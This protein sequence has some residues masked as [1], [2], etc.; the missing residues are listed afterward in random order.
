MPMSAPHSSSA[1]VMAQ[2]RA[3]GTRWR[4]RAAGDADAMCKLVEIGTPPW[5]DP[6][7][8]GVLRRVTRKYEA[9]TTEPAPHSWFSFGA[10]YDTPDYVAMYEADEDYGKA[11]HCSCGSQIAPP[12]VPPF[13]T[14]GTLAS[15][16]SPGA[17]LSP[18]S[19]AMS[20][21][22]WQVRGVGSKPPAQR[23]GSPYRL[24]GILGHPRAG[25]HPTI[26]A[27]A[28]AVSHATP[29]SRC[30]GA[31]TCG[32]CRLP[33]ARHASASGC[34]GDEMFGSRLHSG[35]ARLWVNLEATPG[36]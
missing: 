32:R 35:K 20:A 23:P 9:K 16:I 34:N 14:C 13:F 11:P 3:I 36:A 30:A 17:R 25:W 21:F 22:S 29:V 6:R 33:L 12:Y 2:R 8:F 19:K 1:I 10:G 18:S 15:A 28:V 26:L 7:A 24:S 4:W 31:W 5:T 27:Q